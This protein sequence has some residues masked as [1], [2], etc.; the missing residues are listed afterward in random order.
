MGRRRVDDGTEETGGVVKRDTLELE[1][2]LMGIRE[3]RRKAAIGPEQDD[4]EGNWEER[5]M[6]AIERVSLVKKTKKRVEMTMGSLAKG[7]GEELV[8]PTSGSTTLQSTHTDVDAG[9]GLRQPPPTK[10]A[11]GKTK[12]QGGLAFLEKMVGL[13]RKHRMSAGR[14]YTRA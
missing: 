14:M 5:A 13:V 12:V 10:E 7:V 2:L 6:G 3:G 9:P 1:S 11:N 4:D 8:T